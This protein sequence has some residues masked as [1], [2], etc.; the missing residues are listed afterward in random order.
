MTINIREATPS[1]PIKLKCPYCNTPISS[2]WLKQGGKVSGVTI[3]CKRCGK[4]LE[5]TVE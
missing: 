2:F 3:K 1:E 4:T 5:I